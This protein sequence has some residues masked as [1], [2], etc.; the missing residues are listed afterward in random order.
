M[1]GEDRALSLLE[2]I[3]R[4]SPGDQTEV[5]L[6]G[7]ESY[8][9]RFATNY[10]HQNVAEKNTNLS[11]KVIFGKKIGVANTNSL[12]EEV[13]K[14]AVETAAELARV[15]E[16]NPD[17][18]S[19]PGPEPILR[20]NAFDE[21]T[22][23]F[24]PAQRAQEVKKIIDQARREGFE[25]SGAFSTSRR[26]IAVANSLG[27]RAYHRAT[28]AH[29]TTVVMTG[30]GSGFA[31]AGGH[32][33]ADVDAGSIGARAVEKC[34]TS[35]GPIEVPPGEYEVI[36]E[37]PAVADLLGYLVRLVFS[38]LAYQEG[39]SFLVG[40]L[41]Q[42]IVG[43]NITVWDDGLDP[44]GLVLPFDFE[45]VPKRRLSL[46]EAG[47]AKNLAYDSFT[48]GR[49]GKSST[50]HA[51]PG[52]MGGFGPMPLNVF[53]AAGESTLEEMIASTGRGILV[54]RFHYTNPI[55]PIRAMITG[56]TRDGTFLIEDGKIK[57]PVKNFRFT[58]SVLR[59]FSNVE[60]IS[61]RRAL[62]GEFGAVV[63]PAIK[64]RVFNFTGVTEF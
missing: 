13:L 2:K 6:M 41:G 31:E 28:L 53:M 24:T 11:V 57:A 4:L 26:E 61:R 7:G 47:V 16:E 54:T 49:E 12:E 15:Q 42:K 17:F 27:V 18:K 22:A 43:D 36:L 23:E 3:L 37:E 51:I 52:G 55:H 34:Q 40:R 8:L 20:V 60:Q 5:T 46:I 59:V 62:H 30:D 64:A 50:G 39:R 35:R 21:A 25:A 19:L 10:I 56:M 33:V 14:R 9:T 58:E 44:A 32:R 45:G 48:A 38:A 1:L 63:V 29:L